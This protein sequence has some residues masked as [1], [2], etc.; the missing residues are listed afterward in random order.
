MREIHTETT[1]AVSAHRVWSILTD[2]ARY[3]AW[4]PFITQ[5]EGEF[6]EGERLR[7]RIH[8]VDGSPM[9][10]K[11]VVLRA[12]PGRELRWLG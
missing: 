9:I 7:V 6:A 11:P 8:P 12:A 10:F 2:V 1:I 3:P 4:N 5:I